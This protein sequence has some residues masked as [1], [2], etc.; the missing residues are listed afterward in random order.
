MPMSGFKS[1]HKI[2]GDGSWP[3]NVRSRFMVVDA[4]MI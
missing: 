2:Y 1:M 4:L 3:I